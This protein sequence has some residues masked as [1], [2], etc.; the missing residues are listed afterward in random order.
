[1]RPQL[2]G[3]P[4]GRAVRF[5]QEVPRRVTAGTKRGGSGPLP[6]DLGHAFKGLMHV[7]RLATGRP[8]WSMVLCNGRERRMGMLRL[9]FLS[10][11]LLLLLTLG[12]P[13]VRPKES[14]EWNDGRLALSICRHD[15]VEKS[16][17]CAV[18]P[19]L[20]RSRAASMRGG[21]ATANSLNNLSGSGESMA[22][23]SQ[24]VLPWTAR[25]DRWFA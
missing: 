23:L 3:K 5:W 15:K 6:W 10:D 2:V 18:A 1:V 20:N 4:N 13:A 25:S 12:P 22:Q 19:W 9:Y 24:R 21:L 7:V 17:G 16:E 11:D 14:R 8:A